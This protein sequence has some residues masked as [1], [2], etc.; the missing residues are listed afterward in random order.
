MAYLK[1]RNL[2]LWRVDQIVVHDE[3]CYESHEDGSGTAEVPHVVI[4]VKV[5]NETVLVQ[6]SR[7]G[8]KC[9]TIYVAVGVKIGG[10][11][12]QCKGDNGE[13]DSGQPGA[14]LQADVVAFIGK[15]DPLRDG[16]EEEV[17]CQVGG[18]DDKDRLRDGL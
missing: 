16:E 1:D 18:E 13:Y 3:Q 12:S 17:D 7:F 11:E 6:V 10:N 5:S 8:R 4:V 14:V 2:I 15:A 9:V